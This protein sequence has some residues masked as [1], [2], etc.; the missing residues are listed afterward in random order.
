MIELDRRL[1]SELANA[2]QIDNRLLNHLGHQRQ[3]GVGRA[4]GKGVSDAYING[5]MSLDDSIPTR[6]QVRTTAE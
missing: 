6:L 2:E 3:A 4:D 5:S 1:N